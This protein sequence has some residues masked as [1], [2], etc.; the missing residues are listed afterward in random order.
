[1]KNCIN[2][3]FF[4]LPESYGEYGQCTEWNEKYWLWAKG[5]KKHQTRE[6]IRDQPEFKEY[7]K[8]ARK[9]AREEAKR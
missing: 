3:A 2:C 6:E 4:I 5:C 7:I 9:I 8:L 1:M